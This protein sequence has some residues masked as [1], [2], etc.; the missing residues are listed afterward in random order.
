VNQTQPGGF[1]AGPPAGEG[2]G[3]LA[4][5][6]SWGLNNRIKA[7]C[8]RLSDAS[9]IAFAPHLDHGMVPDIIPDGRPEASPPPGA[10]ASL[11][12]HESLVP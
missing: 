8:T 11:R 4:L 10:F 2:A 3:A 5:Q 9:F 6:A 12:G 7:L 1:L